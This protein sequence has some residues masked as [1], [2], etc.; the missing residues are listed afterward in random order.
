MKLRFLIV[1]NMKG[2]VLR[3]TN[4][5]VHGLRRKGIE[6][7]RI[8]LFLKPSAYSLNPTIMTKIFLGRFDGFHI[9]FASPSLIA[10]LRRKVGK[11]PYILTVHGAPNPQIET[12]CIYKSL[13]GI[14]DVLLPIVGKRANECLAISKYVAKELYSRY[15]VNASVIY[16]GIDATQY[17]YRKDWRNQIRKKLKIRDNE[18]IFLFVGR[19][20][21]AKDPV[22]L[23]LAMKMF[24][25]RNETPCKLLIIGSGELENK[26]KLMIKLDEK[27]KQNVIF[28][29]EVLSNEVTKYYSASDAL[30]LP[31]IIEGFGYVAIEAMSSPI[32]V[33][34]STACACPEVV[35]EGGIFFSPG[36]PEDLSSKLMLL[37]ENPDLRKKL[38]RRGLKRVKDLFTAERMVNDYL[39][40]YERVVR[41]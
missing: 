8:N 38:A 29:G 18:T 22:T 19:L 7:E 11:K 40:A 16:P 6:V 4:E 14:E 20:H 26:L 23:L 35:G 28:I 39:A 10:L 31:S 9:N 3:F 32:P 36:N 17:R 30:V 1:S 15:E 34:A 2:G 41:R 24:L 37:A 5:L 25:S 12:S 21:E 27:L 13:Y 33:I